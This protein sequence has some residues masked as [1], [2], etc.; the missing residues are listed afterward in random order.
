MKYQ[1]ARRSSAADVFHSAKNGPVTVPNPYD[2]LEDLNSEETQDFVTA[3]NAAFQKFLTDPKLAKS[4]AHLSSQLRS[5]YGMTFMTNVPQ[6]VGDDYFFRVAG[7]GRDFPVTYRCRRE[8]FSALSN[9]KA[10]NGVALEPE[11]FYDE[12]TGGGVLISSGFSAS[13][14]YWAYNTSFKG[15]DW[16]VVRVRDTQT[17]ESLP[18]EVH[19][20]KFTTTTGTPITWLG[21]RGFFYQYWPGGQQQASIPQLRFHFVATSQEADELVYQD[22]VNPGHTFKAS[23]SLDG[24]LVFLQIYKAGRTC[25]VWA[26]RVVPSTGSDGK[27]TQS[28]NLRFD[29]EI[30]NDFDYEWE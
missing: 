4:K 30:C 5:M 24:S 18:D 26:A 1:T 3:Q 15:S 13:G 6:A 29:M 21:D 9:G 25:Q 7:R 12:E 16:G 20:T 2:W 27:N 11:V 10:P 23:V 28:L 22:S 8:V 19:N 17:S 14:A